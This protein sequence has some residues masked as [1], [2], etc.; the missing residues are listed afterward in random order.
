[1]CGCLVGVQ[2]LMAVLQIKLFVAISY[3]TGTKISSFNDRYIGKQGVIIV[4]SFLS[5]PNSCYLSH[6]KEPHLTGAFHSSDLYISIVI[7]N[8]SEMN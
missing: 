4:L 6:R 3:F 5:F 8:I 7:L 1:M 2:D